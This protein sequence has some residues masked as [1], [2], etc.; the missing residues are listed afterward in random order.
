MMHRV[1]AAFETVSADPLYIL[2]PRSFIS[3]SATNY[4][5]TLVSTKH[6]RARTVCIPGLFAKWRATDSDP[7]R[8]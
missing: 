2:M 3:F 4:F 8:F 7:L 6:G 5:V 1:V